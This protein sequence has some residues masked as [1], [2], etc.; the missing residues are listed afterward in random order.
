MVCMM[1]IVLC[2]FE[3]KRSLIYKLKS[4]KYVDYRMVQKPLD[5]VN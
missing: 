2:I 4:R 1:N 3:Y 5:K